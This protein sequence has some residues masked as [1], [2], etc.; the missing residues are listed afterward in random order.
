MDSK[1]NH[2]RKFYIYTSR[3]SPRVKATAHGSNPVNGYA[4]GKTGFYI[5]KGLLKKKE[6]VR[7]ATCGS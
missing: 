5:Y 3:F 6:Y 2:P 4:Q 7:E 1:Q